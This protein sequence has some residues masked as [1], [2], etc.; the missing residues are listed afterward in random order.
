MRQWHEGA[1]VSL[2]QFHRS[3][4]PRLTLLVWQVIVIKSTHIGVDNCSVPVRDED[5]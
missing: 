5:I 1:P 3:K 4:L 2:S